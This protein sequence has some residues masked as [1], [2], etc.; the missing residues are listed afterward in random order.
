VAI[1][2]KVIKYLQDEGLFGEGGGK[3]KM[4]DG[5]DISLKV[6]RAV[7]SLYLLCLWRIAWERR[8]N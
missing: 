4:E 1:F 2:S 3:R 8:C 7:Y 5:F 6:F